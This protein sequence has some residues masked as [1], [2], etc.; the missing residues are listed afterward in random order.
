MKYHAKAIINR[1]TPNL[2]DS[3]TIAI[4]VNNVNSLPTAIAAGNPV[5]DTAPLTVSFTGGNSFDP[6]GTITSHVWTFGDGNSSSLPDESD[7]YL[8][9]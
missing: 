9:E 4:T 8:S 6:N 2:S 3:E 7:P 1:G 5:S